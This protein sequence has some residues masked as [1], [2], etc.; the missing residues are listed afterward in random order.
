M[1]G[2]QFKAAIKAIIDAER[3]PVKQI[4]ARKAKEDAK[5]KLFADFKSKF[6]GFDK[7]LQEFSNFRNF[8]ELKADLGDGENFAAV[9]IDKNRAEPGNYNIEIDSLAQRSSIISNG[10]KDPKDK[11]LGTGYVTVAKDDGTTTELY[12]NSDD[13][14]LEGVAKL[15]NKD[16]ESP[17]QAS[18][19][20]DISDSEQWKLIVTS[21]KDG[22]AG[23]VTFPE[24]YFMGGEHDFYID[25]NH[26]FEGAQIKIDGFPIT[27]ESN[28]IK[29]FVTGVNLHLKQSRPD[30]P[31]SLTITE[32]HAKVTG[33][34]K[35]MVDQLNGILEFINK[36]NQVD[37]KSDTSAGFT[38]D[39]S[40]SSIEYRLRNLLHEGFPGNDWHGSDV[41]YIF[42]NQL[43]I[44]FEKDGKLSFKEDRFNKTLETDFSG[45][46]EAITGEFGL[47]NQLR[48]VIAGYTR[49]NT[50]VLAIRE[51]SMRNNIKR[52]D[53]DIA[54]K[55]R[56]IEQKQEALTEKFSRL[57]GSLSAMQQQQ[58]S[59]SA[60]MG[61]G[62]GGNL[63]QQLLGG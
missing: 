31:I 19:V 15:I 30:K 42:T 53:A 57:Q 29:D 23:K 50:G 11:V 33:K 1:G 47:A 44:E 6:T 58:Q 12:V 14:S 45:V 51:T 21:K 61:G 34:V 2:G 60:S 20:Q 4:E 54:E 17:I 49:P 22:L 38:G 5:I 41:R 13:S 62:G 43:G 24:F 56:R 10:F 18:V 16:R 36:Q 46:S 7:T 26:D 48:D 35:G 32:D 28:E 3:Q 55:E 39:S 27:A 52:M 37:E 25:D 40:L 59:L 9:T 8:R 63:V